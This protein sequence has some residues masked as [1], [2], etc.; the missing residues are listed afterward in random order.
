MA[1]KVIKKKLGGRIKSLLLNTKQT[2]KKAKKLSKRG[3]K[4][5]KGRG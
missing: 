5:A 2:P 1:A 3:S 4:K